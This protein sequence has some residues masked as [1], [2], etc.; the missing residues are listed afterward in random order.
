MKPLITY[1]VKILNLV[2]IPIL[3]DFGYS[4]LD[5]ISE[6]NDNTGTL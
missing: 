4:L 6:K 3:G 1:Y 2:N 5:T